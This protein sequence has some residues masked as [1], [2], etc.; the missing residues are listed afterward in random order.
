MEI[1]K[2]SSLNDLHPDIRSL[3][4]SFQG[5]THTTKTL[6]HENKLFMA[7]YSFLD[8]IPLHQDFVFYSPQ[9]LLYL[10]ERGGL[11]LFAIHLRTNKGPR[12]HV[13]TQ[14][15]PP[16]K[17]LFAKMHVALADAQSHQF[18][19]HL[20]IHLMM[21][22]AAIARNNFLGKIRLHSVSKSREDI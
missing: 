17:F 15:S 6:F 8:S 18:V 3:E 11:E 4:I 7:D 12:S 5:F 16:N 20:A 10:N 14:L 19:H 13:M 22:S 2:V 1:R 21:E 9:V